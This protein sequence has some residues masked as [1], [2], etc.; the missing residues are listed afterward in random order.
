MSIETAGLDGSLSADQIEKFRN[1][2]YLVIPGLFS[3]DEM[4]RI[5][6][7]VDETQTWPEESG[8]AWMYFEQTEDGRRQLNR[9]EKVLAFHDG[10]R[11]LA[12]GRRMRGVC[13]QLF[14]EPAVLFKDKI[15]FKLPGGGGF[16]A[17]QDVQ[18]GWARYGSLH[19]TAVISVDQATRA[20]G[21]LEMARDFHKHRLI[22]REWE[23]LTEEDLADVQFEFL[24]AQ[25][26][27][28]VF[29]DSFIPHRSEPNHTDQSRRVLYVT[30]GKA[31]EGEQMDKYYA[32]KFE[33]YPPDI[34]REAGREYRY[35]V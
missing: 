14:G 32:D 16:D 5:C 9:M 27:D 30:F 21:C 7:W 13:S 29:F 19:I 26:G 8:G 22:G 11:E 4:V 31:S 15:N 2:G 6:A 34:E 28:G 1:D 24:E 33:S 17:H 10:L 18:A 3:S 23:P 25:P 12:M 20:N 35:R